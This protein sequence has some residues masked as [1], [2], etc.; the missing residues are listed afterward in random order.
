[1]LCGEI[2]PTLALTHEQALAVVYKAIDWHRILRQD[3]AW[4]P[5]KSMFSSFLLSFRR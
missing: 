4:L 5:L 1:M 3:G 2:P